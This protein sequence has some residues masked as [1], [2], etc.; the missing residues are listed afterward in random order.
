LTQRPTGVDVGRIRTKPPGPKS[1]E[2][3]RRLQ[4]VECRE[5]TFVGPNAP[6]FLA[7]GTG[8]NLVDV[9][10]NVY[11][12]LTAAFAVA[13]VGHSDLSVVG[14][15]V[16]QAE[17]L[18]HGMGDVYPTTGKVELAEALCD[19]AP[20]NRPKRVIFAASGAE[21]VEAALKTAMVASGKPGVV[22]FDGAYHGLT[23]GAL[24]LTDGDHFRKPF[25]AQLGGFVRRAPFPRGDAAG[26]QRV[27]EILDGP[28]GVEVGSV[29][30]EP[31]LGRG[32]TIPA[33]DGWLAGLR[34]LCERKGLILILDEIFTGFGRTGRWFACEHAEVVPDLL[35]VG[36]GMAGG[37]PIAACIG[38]AEL[39]D[40]W[41]ASTGEAVH[42]S[43]FIGNPT[44]CA[45]ALACIEQIRQLRLVER[46]AKLGE[47]LA[48]ML[49]DVRRASRGRI[50]DVRGRGLMWGLECVDAAGE[51]DA[52]FAQQ[53]VAGALERGVIVLT[54]G[55]RSNIIQI[56][57]PLVISDEQLAF[58]VRAIRE[59]IT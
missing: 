20:G 31:I 55:L 35:C 44:G 11:V 5:V 47:R 1:R 12:D 43:T 15:V 53:V 51:P 4:E 57:P 26:L 45:A 10:D 37:F 22:A 36:K 2:L 8:A 48:P 14:A 34:A 21:A 41:P 29:I 38:S 56:N 25:L 19:V 16:R 33:P 27:E 9:D 39:M 32:G 50:G 24:A 42:T 49:D 18:L 30:V 54:G 3:T 28:A 46:A 6:I 17:T 58:G 23:Y 52:R 40:R 59:A 7:G 13:S